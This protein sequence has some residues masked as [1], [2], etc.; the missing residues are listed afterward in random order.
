M[1]LWQS[2]NNSHSCITM[3]TI[4]SLKSSLTG[5]NKNMPIWQSIKIPT[6]YHKYCTGAYPGGPTLAGTR[7]PSESLIL[8]PWCP[9]P[10]NLA[11]LKFSSLETLLAL[12]WHPSHHIDLS[13]YLFSFLSP[14]CLFCFFSPFPLF[15][16]YFF[17]FLFLVILGPALVT[18]GPPK[19]PP[20]RYDPAIG[21]IMIRFKLVHLLCHHDRWSIM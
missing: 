1:V 3:A 20:P 13:F 8:A 18:P 17:S 11:P 9:R 19:P 6:V 5:C 21:G 4:Y 15:F 2:D 16:P 14:S 12:E 10:V 7:G